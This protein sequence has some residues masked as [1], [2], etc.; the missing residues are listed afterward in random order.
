MNNIDVRLRY[1]GEGRAYMLAM[2]CRMDARALS[3]SLQEME[4]E[5]GDLEIAFISFID[6]RPTRL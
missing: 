4:D 6:G 1:L 2:T 5:V 3:I